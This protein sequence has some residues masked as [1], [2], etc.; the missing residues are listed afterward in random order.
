LF[1]SAERIG[2]PPLSRRKFIDIDRLSL[3]LRSAAEGQR[4][5]VL[6]RASRADGRHHAECRRTSAGRICQQALWQERHRRL[7]ENLRH[8]QD[9]APRVKVVVLEQCL[10]ITPPIS[11]SFLA[12]LINSSASPAGLLR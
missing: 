12:L 1:K 3:L 11:R 5:C 4:A 8:G 10:F 6:L 2:C 7:L 9:L